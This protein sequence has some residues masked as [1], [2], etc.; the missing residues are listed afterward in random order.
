[1]ATISSLG[2][3]S[4]LDLSSIVTGLVD[5]ERA[6]TEARLSLKEE[7]ITTQLSAFGALKSSLSIF[8]GSMG[9]LLSA[10][11]YNVKQAALSDTS[12]FSASITNSADI[13]SYAVEVSALAKSQSLATSA[14]TAFTDINDTVGSGTLTIR[15]GTTTTG[16]YTFTQDTTKATQVITVSAANNNT[17]LSGLR[18]YINDNDFGVQAAI[19]NDGSGYRL[20]LTS[21]NSGAANSMEITVTDDGDSNNNDNA[22]LSQLAFN[23]SAQTSML[24]TVQAQDAA[25]KI[26]GLDITRETNTVTGAIDGV[27]L[28]LLKD[29][30]GN[31]VSVNVTESSES[32]STGIQEFVEG[33]N[34]LTNTIKTLTS[35]N[36]ETQEAGI[37]IGDATVRSISNQ[38]SNIVSS[39]VSQLTGNIQSLSDIGIKTKL[40][41]TLELDLS[42]LNAALASYPDEVAALFTLQGRPTDSGVSYVSAGDATQPGNYSV[43]VT[44]LASQAVF[45][46]SVV[47]NLT[48]D[49]NN[50]TFTIKVDGVT[51]NVIN[52]TQAV[53]ADGFDLAAH[54]QAQINDDA[55]IK[56]AGAGVSVAY[57]SVNNEFDIT[58]LSYGSQS[59]LEFV[60][61]D[62]NTT[63]DLGFSVGSGTDGND[64]AG[65]INGLNASGNGQT[66]TSTT[67]DSEGL[68]V[69]ITSGST[70]YRGGVSFSR[71][72]ATA[73][74]E[75]ITNF[76]DSSGS[77]STRENGL[78]SDLE[79]ISEQRSRLDLK[80]SS[81]EARLVAQF[82]ALDSL[83]SQ[84]N[85]TSSFLTQQLA[86][87]PKPNSIGRNNN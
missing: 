58:S 46:G 76:L 14:A 21:E 3:G 53:Y 19:V 6:P 11:S 74:D 65:T 13:G 82:S 59:K 49:A 23:A 33:F 61:V 1:M 16:P 73:M 75:L 70:G 9:T 36:S 80:I 29:D 72:T 30:V 37:L 63:N 83:I 31:I 78:T 44:T 57:D 40:D 4:G 79:D 67:G 5:A 68:A 56:A 25:L 22:G 50:D 60:A 38:L 42:T 15:F 24:Q 41:G 69:L 47:N 2:I 20:T 18:D 28:N 8:Q 52:L 77:I 39:S 26:N 84:F 10:S 86:N 45:N 7:K 48:I 32:L 27:T 12:V 17:T 87:L 54:I 35:Y 34:G 64:V 62:T 51:S 66:L 81:L 55:A 43:N 71:G 85:N